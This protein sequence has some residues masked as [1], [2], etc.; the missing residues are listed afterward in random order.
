MLICAAQR[1]TDIDTLRPLSAAARP[2]V[3]LGTLLLCARVAGAAEPGDADAAF[4]A[5]CARCHTPAEITRRL[6]DDWNGRPAAE[7]L[8]TI[9]A[10]MPAESPGSL[11]DLEYRQTL[12]YLLRLVDIELAPTAP[13][14]LAGVAIDIDE[15]A[16]ALLPDVAWRH[17]GGQLNAN[18]YAP[19]ADIDAD[20][21]DR[22]V[23]AWR[24]EARN[25]GPRPEIRNVSMPIMRD[26]RLFIGAGATRNVVAI[27]AVTGQTLWM[28]RPE[29]GER[30]EQAARKDSGKGMAYYDHPDGRGRVIT[31]TPGYHLVSLDARSG[32]P[33]R[34]FGKA[35]QVDL[36]RGLRRAAGRELDIGLTAP[37]LVMGDVIVVGS[38][39]AVSFRPPSSAN[40][41]GDVRA[42]D[43]RTG[44]QLWA[45]HTIP[46]P[47]C[48]RVGA[49]VGGPGART[50]LPA[51]GG[52]HGRSVRR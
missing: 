43:A 19:L 27:D 6:T 42:F 38:A 21:V 15:A 26:G 17:F 48:G 11:T 25:F 28:W 36:T 29:E 47:G 46:A 9:R 37:P 14:D 1:L 4:G 24:W 50:G 18:R 2:A 49:H 20:N 12:R 13:A 52:R 23:I 16:P 5:H 33:D 3:L 7:L 39:H 34:R 44:R 8:D 41:K 32:L 22:L 35:G 45:F 51:G 40:V 30:F 31:V 10:T